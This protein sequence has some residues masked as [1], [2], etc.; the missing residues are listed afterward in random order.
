MRRVEVLHVVA[1]LQV[2]VHKALAS[3]AERLNRKELALL[4]LR[5]VASLH[6]GDALACEQSHERS[7]AL[8]KKKQAQQSDRRTS[9]NAIR[10]NAV[11]IQIP[12]TLN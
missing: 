1:A 12:H 11:S 7:H 10:G 6:N 2:L 9:V 8:K 4:H 5:G 3:A